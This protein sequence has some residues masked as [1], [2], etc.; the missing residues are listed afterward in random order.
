MCEKCGHGWSSHTNPCTDS[1]RGTARNLKLACAETGCTCGYFNADESKW[2]KFED[3][4]KECL[5]QTADHFYYVGITFAGNNGIGDPTTFV[6]GIDSNNEVCDGVM[7]VLYSLDQLP[8]GAGTGW[9]RKDGS[10]YVACVPHSHNWNYV[11]DGETLNAYCT[12][13]DGCAYE[14]E[15]K[16]VSL[17]L[18]ASNANY[19]GNY[20]T[21]SEDGTNADIKLSGKQAWEEAGLTYEVAYYTAYTDEDTNTPTSTTNGCAS[22]K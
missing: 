19:S 12:K 8:S 17:T 6:M 9:Y 21:Y 11:A 1:Q 10:T 3:H 7:D 13:T 18:S 4:K 14:G 20:V 2:P 22:G 16:A 15:Q 5:F